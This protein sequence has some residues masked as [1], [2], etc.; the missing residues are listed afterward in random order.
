[1]LSSFTKPKN[2]SIHEDSNMT[3]SVLD[4]TALRRID[5]FGVWSFMLYPLLL[6]LGW[7]LIA[8]F[9]PPHSPAADAVSIAALYQTHSVRIIVGMVITLFAAM[10]LIP[11]TGLITKYI[12]RA[13]GAVGVLTVSQFLGG[14]ALVLFTFL[15]A[16]YWIA[17]AFRGD[18]MPEIVQMAND[19]A[20]MLLVGGFTIYIPVLYSI[21]YV[22]LNDKSAKPVFPRWI[23]FYNLWTFLLFL[24]GQLLYFFKVGPFAWNGIIA[25]WIPIGVFGGWFL[26]MFYV[27][28]RAVLE[29]R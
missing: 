15:P 7:V 18:R 12:Y 25:F 11:L 28:R 9:V 23:G 10:F 3:S 24:P 22:A 2:N 5:L 27:L 1:M 20:W 16:M 8:G 4:P 26:A 13:E 19:M 29:D 14:F 21:A 6:T 17:A